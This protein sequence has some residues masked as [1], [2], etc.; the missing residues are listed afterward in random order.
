MIYPFFPQP[1]KS[2]SG[3][4][5]HKYIRSAAKRGRIQHN[6]LSSPVTTMYQWIVEPTFEGSFLTERRA[7]QWNQMT[8]VVSSR[9]RC[10]DINL[11]HPRSTWVAQSV[12]RLNLDFWLRL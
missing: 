12:K 11:P 1:P 5:V 3:G 10:S 7:G 4:A 9:L 6:A 8:S 2:G